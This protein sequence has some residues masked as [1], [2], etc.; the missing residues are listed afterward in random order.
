MAP[1]MADFLVPLVCALGVLAGGFGALLGLGGGIFL[2]P[3]LVTGLQLPYAAARGVSLL[4]VIATSSAVM[5]SGQG[6]RSANLR[7]GMLLQVAAAAGGLAGG[8]TAAFVPE[9]ALTLAFALVTAIVALAMRARLD[10][11]NVVFDSSGDPGVLGGRFHDVDT[12]RE[13]VYHVK[14]VPLALVVAFVSGNVSSLLGLGGGIL[15]V[16]ALN[17]W[18]GVPMRVAAT[19]SAFMIGVTAVSAA[20][21]Y[22]L[23]GEVDPYLAAAGVLGVLAGTRLGLRLAG[24]LRARTLKLSMIVVLVTVSLMMFARGL[25]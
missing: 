5:A 23:R 10:V 4:S 15:L 22:Y 18:H 21:I 7:L 3:L 16:P 14:R 24:R 1:P 6:G 9:Q 19:T 8:L 13:A 11:R 20:P 2:V 25:R 12:D 17:A